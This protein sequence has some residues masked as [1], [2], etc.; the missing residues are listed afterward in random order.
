[1][2]CN[3][4]NGQLQNKKYSIVEYYRKI[5]IDEKCLIPNIDNILDKLGKAQYF[6]TLLLYQKDSIRFQYSSI[7]RKLFFLHL[8]GTMNT[9]ASLLD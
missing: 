5:T 1:M 9:F 2:H 4:E 6:T 3:K 8:L 7:K